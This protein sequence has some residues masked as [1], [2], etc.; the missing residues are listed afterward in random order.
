MFLG[1]VFIVKLILDGIFIIFFFNFNCLLCGNFL[2][3]IIGICGEIN[4]FLG[5][6]YLFN[7]GGIVGKDK[8]LL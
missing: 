4:F 2:I 8:L 6:V 7:F 5:C 1:K 3:C